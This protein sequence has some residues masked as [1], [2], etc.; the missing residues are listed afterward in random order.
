MRSFIFTAIA[1]ITLPFA[2]SVSL[3]QGTDPNIA[4][5]HAIGE[6]KTIDAAAKQLSIKTDAG[7][8]V[9]VSVSDKTIYKRLAPGETTLANAADITFADIAQGDRVMARGTVSE[10]RKSVPASVLIVMTKG[11]LAKKQEAERLE[12]RRRGILGV[13]TALKPD[14]KEITINNRTMAGVQSVVIPVSDQTEMRRYAPD[15][16]KFGDAKPSTFA[17][18]KVGDQLRALGDRTEDPLR[19]NPQKVVTGSFRTVGGVVTAVDPAT[20]EIKI[21]DLEKKTPLT[22]IVKQDAVLRRFPSDISAMMGG[23]GRGPGGPGGAPAA[24]AN[25][26]PAAPGGQGQ[27]ANR[28]QGGG[29]GGGPGGPGGGPGRGGFNINDM[30]ERLPVISVTDVKVGDTI[31]VSSTQGVDPTRLT[32]ISLVA[33]ADTLLAMLAPRPQPGQAAPNPAAGLGN[34][35]ITFGIGLP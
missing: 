4:A 16:I 1:L 22:I 9:T 10:D 31:I 20:G 5:K 28:P 2:G 8:D 19:F 23:M 25:T 21:N 15:S 32:A 11:D 34:S 17:E 30:L 18:L 33:G 3:A 27:P 12:W 29:P 7:S 13:I 26:S 24:P 14:T 6:V 35:G